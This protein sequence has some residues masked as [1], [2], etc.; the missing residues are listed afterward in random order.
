MCEGKGHIISGAR[1]WKGKYQP[2]EKADNG[3]APDGGG[4]STPEYE[5]E[6]TRHEANDDSGERTC[7]GLIDRDPCCQPDELCGVLRYVALAWRVFLWSPI[8]GFLRHIFLYG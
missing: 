4:G 3:S 1:R 6:T 2:N 8:A 7:P 5:C